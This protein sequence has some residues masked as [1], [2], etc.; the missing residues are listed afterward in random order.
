M[1]ESVASRGVVGA[2]R[3][4]ALVSASPNDVTLS[5]ELIDQLWS[6][7]VLFHKSSVGLARVGVCEEHAALQQGVAGGVDG[8][9]IFLIHEKNYLAARLC[10]SG[11][12]TCTHSRFK[13]W[14]IATN[15]VRQDHFVLGK[16][17]ANFLVE[18]IECF[19][20]K[21]LRLDAIGYRGRATV[22]GFDQ[23]EQRDMF[24]MRF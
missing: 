18:R 20:G 1:Q 24:A 22:F 9:S 13:R 10:Q 21:G 6:A 11:P 23:Q 16:D 19:A 5:H 8:A 17:G 4:C 3:D 2:S 14:V 15:L 12:V 7:S